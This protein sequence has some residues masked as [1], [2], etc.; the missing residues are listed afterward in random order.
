MHYKLFKALQQI[1]NNHNYFSLS[2]FLCLQNRREYL[3]NNYG[4]LR[5]EIVEV[6]R[7]EKNFIQCMYSQGEMVNEFPFRTTLIISI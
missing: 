1:N 5:E 4:R 2:H 7:H 3:L 6:V